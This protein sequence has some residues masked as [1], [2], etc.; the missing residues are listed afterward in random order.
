M[1]RG[2]DGTAPPSREGESERASKAQHRQVGP[3]Y[4]RKVACGRVGLSGPKGREGRG[5]GLLFLF[6]YSKFLNSFS[7][8]FSFGLKFKHAPNSNLKVA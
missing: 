7:F 6:F 2:A 4:K 3:T 1:D 8:V 5:F